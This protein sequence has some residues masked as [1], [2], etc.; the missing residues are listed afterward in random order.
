MRNKGFGHKFLHNFFPQFLI[1]IVPRTFSFLTAEAASLGR[2]A[3]ALSTGALHAGL[4]S[5]K[6]APVESFIGLLASILISV[7]TLKLARHLIRHHNLTWVWAAQFAL[8][9]PF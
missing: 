4:A 5:L 6:S 9:Y 3:W 2:S 8:R 7:S 1:G